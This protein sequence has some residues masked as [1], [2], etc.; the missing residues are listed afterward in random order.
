MRSIVHLNTDKRASSV[1]NALMNSSSLCDKTLHELFQS[2]HNP[3]VSNKFILDTRGQ[4]I[5][6][7][8]FS[9]FE[10]DFWDVAL[11]GF[12]SSNEHSFNEIVRSSR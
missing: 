11:I 2:E 10:V 7:H 12:C 5:N 8:K 6:K 9:H 4:L 1:R 3:I